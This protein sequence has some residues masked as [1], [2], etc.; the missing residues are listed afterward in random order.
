VTGLSVVDTGTTYS[1]FGQIVIML[2]I[3][4]GG[5]G[6][7]VIFNVIQQRRWKKLSLHTKT[8]LVTT[9]ILLLAGFLFTFFMEL[10]NPHTFGKLDWSERLWA[11]Y[12][13]SVTPRTAGFNTLDIGAMT[14]GSQFFMI[15][16][17][18]IGASSGFTG[19]GIK[20]F[21]RSCAYR[22][23]HYPRQNRSSLVPP[24]NPI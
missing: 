12:F 7:T 19:G 15:L 2:F 6:F 17:M 5:I 8:V 1:L 11:A 13:Q 18:F 4:V 20:H 21:R 24:K 14:I 10:S 9:A 23:E 3:Q 16:L 22:L